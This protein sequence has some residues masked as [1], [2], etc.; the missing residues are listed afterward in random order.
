MQRVNNQPIYLNYKRN[1][2][3]LGIID[4]KS[5]IILV[6][7]ILIVVNILKLLPL[8]LEYLIYIFIFLV[9]PVAGIAIININ[10]ESVIDILITIISFMLNGKIYVKLEFKENFKKCIYINYAKQQ[11]ENNKVK[12]FVP[13]SILFYKKY[14]KNY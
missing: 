1:R 4:Y 13:K 10:N 14:R 6:L 8:K 7:Y 3:W 11:V 5:L 2:K 9:V 12:K